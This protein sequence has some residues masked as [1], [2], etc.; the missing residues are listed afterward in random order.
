MNIADQIGNAIYTSVMVRLK[1]ELIENLNST[2]E[3]DNDS[4]KLRK[5]IFDSLNEQEKK[6]FIEYIE[7]ILE[8]CTTTIL[9]GLEGETHIDLYP[10]DS[11]KLSCDKENVGPYL[12]D[13]F[14]G[15]VEDLKE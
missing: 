15:L 5:K 8:D 13:V 14:V 12:T 2:I 11:I 1:A 7:S 6:Y 10:C 9:A 4:Y 3:V